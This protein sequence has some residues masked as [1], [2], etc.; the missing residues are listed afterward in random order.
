MVFDGRP[1]EYFEESKITNLEILKPSLNDFNGIE[2]SWQEK[3]LLARNYYLYHGN[4]EVVTR[5]KTFDGVHHHE[6]GIA[7]GSWLYNQRHAYPDKL[8]KQ[9][10]ALLKQIGMSF[11]KPKLKASWL[12]KYHLAKKYYEYYGDLEIP[13]T[14]KT[15]NGYEFDEK[16]IALG[17]FLYNQRQAFNGCSSTTINKEQ[18]ALWQEIG[19]RFEHLNREDSWQKKYALAK[20]NYEFYGYLKVS[21][22]FKT[23]D[24]ISEDEKGMALGT[25]LHTQRQAY[26]GKG[27]HVLSAKQIKCLEDIGMVWFSKEKDREYQEQLITEE[28]LLRKQK[29]LLNRLYSCLNFYADNELPHCN[30]LNRHMIESLQVLK[31]KERG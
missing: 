2:E 18:I 7:L 30:E 14:F 5:F 3:Y 22:K 24:G 15:K 10:I 11:D 31:N 29:E 8:S 12:K 28:N 25:W 13:F 27:R 6:K 4:L 9:K 19:M 1:H 23:F 20:N 16:G 21:Q 17:V 26:L